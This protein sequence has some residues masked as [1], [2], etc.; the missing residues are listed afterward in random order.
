MR[1]SQAGTDRE[2]A[3]WLLDIG[4]GRGESTEARHI[5]LPEDML[6][7]TSSELIDFIYPDVDS[8]PP[9]PPHYFLHQMILARRNI[10]VS[11][12]NKDVLDHMHGPSKTFLS[13]EK[14][15]REAGADGEDDQ[16]I[17]VEVLQSI[18]TSCLPSGELML[19]KGCPLILL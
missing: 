10:D 18:E 12:I 7:N 1:L 13:A 17:P 2:F 8:E 14:L 11:D 5:K 4:H 9:P 6:C 19:K 15:I 16:P 3:E